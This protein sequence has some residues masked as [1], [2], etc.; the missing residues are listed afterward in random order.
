VEA[1]WMNMSS[2]A[3]LFNSPARSFSATFSLF[4]TRPT[5]PNLKFALLTTQV[6]AR[7]HA[8]LR[9]C[10]LRRHQPQFGLAVITYHH[11]CVP[12]FSRLFP[13]SNSG[14]RH[15]LGH[16]RRLPQTENTRYGHL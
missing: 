15:D 13:C 14:A 5:S 9:P 11:P 7:V 4:Q 10:S 8:K 1:S 16:R 12:S 6:V 3:L 2:P